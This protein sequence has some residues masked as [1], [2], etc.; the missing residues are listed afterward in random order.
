M[1]PWLRTTV[2]NCVVVES[3]TWRLVTISGFLCARIIHP[4]GDLPVYPT[5]YPSSQLLLHPLSFTQQI[6]IEPVS[7]QSL[8]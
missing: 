3:D 2:L 4:P 1:E 8:F 6:F 5:V 7:C